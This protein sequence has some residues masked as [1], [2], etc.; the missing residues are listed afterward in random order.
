MIRNPPRTHLPYRLDKS[1]SLN[2]VPSEPEEESGEDKEEE[3]G[4]N[5]T[6]RWEKV[7]NLVQED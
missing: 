1:F 6:E 2:P 7:L 3:E 4:E 5:I